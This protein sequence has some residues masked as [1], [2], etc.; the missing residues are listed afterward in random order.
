MVKNFIDVTA[1]S[2]DGLAFCKVVP[3][4]M[5]QLEC[6]RAVGEEIAVLRNTAETRRPLCDPV[7]G[8]EIG[9]AACLFGAQVITER[10]A[11]LPAIVP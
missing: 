7:V 10:P 9:R 6:Y 8:D 2:G 1:K 3:G 4:R 11:G 5:N